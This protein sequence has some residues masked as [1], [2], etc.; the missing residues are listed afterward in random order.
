MNFI[1]EIK[2]N[3]TFVGV[4]V[5]L[6]VVYILHKTGKIEFMKFSPASYP[7]DQQKAPEATPVAANADTA[8]T[9]CDLAKV[10]AS[11][12]LIPEMND[13]VR[14]EAFEFAPKD[15]TNVQFM[16]DV[17]RFGE[18]TQGSSNKIASYDLRSTPANDRTEVSPWLNSTVEPD[19]WRKPLE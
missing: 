1:Q 3:R 4:L 15:M 17:A 10:S 18:D 8:P 6:L 13:V 7:W 16:L 19:L 5:L 2:K 14:D 12:S 11:V 9:E